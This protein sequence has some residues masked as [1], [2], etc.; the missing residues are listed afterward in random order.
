MAEDVA[1]LVNGK[2][3][4]GWEDVS[5]KRSIRALCGSF[6]LSVTEKWAEQ[7]QPWLINPG[8]TCKLL[9]GS[10]QVISGYVDDT[11]PKY[12]ANSR[13][14]GVTGRDKAG[15][16]VDCS[17]EVKSINGLNLFS[18]AKKVAGPFGV[19]V[20]D[21]V[22]DAYRF[23]NATVNPGESAFDALDKQGKLRGVLFV[24]DGNG[25]II[26][27]RAGT[28]KAATELVEGVNILEADAHYDWKNR[29][30]KIT[31]KG[32]ALVGDDPTIDLG[33]K[34]SAVDSQIT[35]Y[36]PLIIVADGL[37]TPQLCTDR[38]KWEVT[39]RSGRAA[40]LNVKVQGWRQA[41]GTLWPINKL[42]RVRSP[43]LG[44]NI[45]LLSSEVTYSKSN[46]G[47]FS[48]ITLVPASAYSFDPTLI[49]KKDPL[50]QLVLQDRVRA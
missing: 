33:P 41:D 14:F 23:T 22:G 32:Q 25:N 16:M 4:F 19:G 37:M 43:Y 12:D 39:V 28:T 49:D 34:G 45:D 9:L 8:D 35:R 3:H 26:I 1:L 50:R 47:T 36:R 27:T 21:Q 44:I 7:Q 20:V 48:V 40:A 18:F 42:I 2:Q 13:S 38:A 6:S 15:D 29:F 24:N 10:D 11:A 5:I 31:A 46:A 30:S 17:T